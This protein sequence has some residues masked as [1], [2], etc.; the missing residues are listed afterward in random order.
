[1]KM[2]TENLKSYIN[3]TRCHPNFGVLYCIALVGHS[4]ADE[5]HVGSL[6][7]H[8]KLILG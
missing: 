6:G 2:R 3:R 4:E 8:M 1:M 5:A 7:P